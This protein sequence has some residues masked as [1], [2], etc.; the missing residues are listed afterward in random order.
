MSW[1]PDNPLRQFEDESYCSS[2]DSSATATKK[3]G[4]S[5]AKT[6]NSPG[7]MVLSQSLDKFTD[8]YERS[9]VPSTQSSQPED[10]FDH[11][12]KAMAMKLRIANHRKAM[13]FMHEMDGAVLRLYE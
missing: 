8:T 4:K 12:A 11:W 6:D 3:K 9:F 1:A 10:V 2:L 5:Q 13:A 7:Y